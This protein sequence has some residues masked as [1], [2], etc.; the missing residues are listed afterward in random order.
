MI[1]NT[2]WNSF[3][4]VHEFPVLKDN[5][6]VDVSIIRGGITGIS[7]AY[8]LKKAGLKVAVLDAGKIGMGTTGHSTGNFYHTVAELFLR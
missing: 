8:F 7:T 3:E 1:S 4:T 6:Q 2:I 5:L